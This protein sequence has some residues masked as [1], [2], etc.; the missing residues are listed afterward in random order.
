MTTSSWTCAS[1]ND[2]AD[3]EHVDI[4]IAHE[5]DVRGNAILCTGKCD[6]YADEKR[7]RPIIVERSTPSETIPP[8]P[9]MY[10]IEPGTGSRSFTRFARA[11]VGPGGMYIA[12]EAPPE[13][14][15]DIS[16]GPPLICRLAPPYP[17]S[18]SDAGAEASPKGSSGAGSSHPSCSQPPQPVSNDE[19]AVFVELNDDCIR[20]LGTNAANSTWICLGGP[21][22]CTKAGQGMIVHWR[23]DGACP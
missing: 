12:F 15:F 17:S 5:E 3:L 20:D 11:C 13:K 22:D 14:K 18:A 19:R 16:C 2:G 21:A 6:Q 7:Y 8:T 1:Q 4:H 10:W 9:T 23:K